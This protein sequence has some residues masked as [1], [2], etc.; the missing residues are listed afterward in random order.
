VGDN[1]LSELAARF[2][3]ACAKNDV[4]RVGGDEFMCT[5]KLAPGEDPLERAK[6]LQHAL[7]LPVV[8]D[9]LKFEVG[10]SIGVALFP[11]HGDSVEDL[12]KY[13]DIAMYDI[14]VRGAA[15]CSLTKRWA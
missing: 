8:F 9:S 13:A 1:V 10:A 11:E 3:S 5:Y 2:R 4:A 6:Q 7:G 15:A 12:L 14:K